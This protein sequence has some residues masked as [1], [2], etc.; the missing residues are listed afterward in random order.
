MNAHPRL[1][2]TGGPLWN[3]QAGGSA[4]FAQP[5]LLRWRGDRFMDELLAVLATPAAER[6]PKL[7]AALLAVADTGAE[8]K[9][10]Q[11]AHGEYTLV[12]ASLVCRVPALPDHLP[13][14]DERVVFVVR[15]LDEKQQEL[16]WVPAPPGAPADGP[17]GSWVAL[18]DPG[19]LAEGEEQ[20]ALFPV[21]WHDHEGRRRVW[22]GVVP[23]SA[24]ERYEAAAMPA[25]A[26]LA[27]TLRT[28]TDD[29]DPRFFDCV[30][31]LGAQPRGSAAALE[32]TR[33]A[34]W[35]LAQVLEGKLGAGWLEAR[36]ESPSQAAWDLVEQ[37]VVPRAG[38]GAGVSL[39]AAAR[40]ARIHGAT[41]LATGTWPSAPPLDLGARPWAEWYA[42]RTQLLA[43]L[44]AAWPDPDPSTAPLVTGQGGRYRVRCCWLRPPCGGRSTEL[45]SAPTIAFCMASFLDL[46]APQRETRIQLPFDVSVAGLRKLK[47][48]VGIVMSAA[49]RKKT[50]AANSKNVLK[51]EAVSEPSVLTGWITIWSIPI[52]TICATILLLII[53]TLLNLV[54]WWLP[55]LRVTVPVRTGP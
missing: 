33:L 20:R 13:E 23:V 52:I 22:A 51:G 50:E 48:S 38:G 2:V 8:P 27:A 54:F 9:L 26:D 44:Q 46:D 6:D 43:K 41:L 11:P 30:R 3:T 32:A 49:M 1:W 47:K 21:P 29:L 39:R 19:R 53:A 31:D 35:D 40:A 7:S 18:A 25:L 36:P 34:L 45:L 4:S 37:A 15:R 17:A 28:W 14:R 55:F 12:L 42:L 24:R 5:A 16:A 10:F